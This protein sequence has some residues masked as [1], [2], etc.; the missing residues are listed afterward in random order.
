MNVIARCR[1]GQRRAIFS[2][3]TLRLAFIFV[4]LPVLPA[5]YASASNCTNWGTISFFA[6]VSLND[7][8]RCLDLGYDP[9]FLDGNAETPLFHMLRLRAPAAYIRVLLEYEANPNFRSESGLRVMHLAAFLTRDPKTIHDLVRAGGRPNEPMEG[10]FFPIHFSAQSNPDARIT[11]ALLENG[12]DP[13]VVNEA[14]W[15]PLASAILFNRN[16]GVA[17]G[18]LGEHLGHYLPRQGT[19]ASSGWQPG[20][21]RARCW[22][23]GP[24]EM[25]GLECFYM[26][27]REDP[28]RDTS[29]LIAFP[30][31]RFF[32]PD[33]KS[34]GS[35]VLKL[36]GGGPGNP[37]GFE[38][39]YFGLHW[40]YTNLAAPAGRDLY[41]MDPRGVG[42]AHPRLYCS[43]FLE[44]HDAVFES[45]E[46][47]QKEQLSL[48]EGYKACK[49]F[50]DRM[51]HDLSQYNS[52][53]VAGDAEALRQAL[54][55]DRWVLFGQSFAARYALTVAREFPRSVEAMVL[56]GAAFPGRGLLEHPVAVEQIPFEKLFAH[57]EATPDCDRETLE[58][59][60][61]RLVN[62]LESEPIT[63]NDPG[64]GIHDGYGRGYRLDRFVLTGARLV[65]LVQRGLVK[66][67]K[68]VK[69]GVL[70]GELERGVTR[71]LRSWLPGYL[72][73]WLGSTYSDPV[74]YAHYCSEIHPL[75][76]FAADA[77]KRGKAPEY[78]RLFNR[79]VTREDEEA[80]CALWGVS[81]ADPVEARS[82]ETDIPTLFL[83]GRLDPVTPLEV[84]QKELKNFGRREVLVFDDLSHADWHGHECAMVAGARFLERKSLD[85]MQG[86][87]A[88]GR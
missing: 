38:S 6:K 37:V 21:H 42:M 57:C 24:A 16:P 79:G 22:F 2:G 5:G 11:K 59:R 4:V 12:A 68:F 72:E 26:V 17:W 71:E 58:T 80:G 77:H 88:D 18:L 43:D 60:F 63:V 7:M 31:V 78:L 56:A 66:A 54:N 45:P 1:H 73:Y 64:H 28:D 41:V 8:R 70:V 32:D 20:L 83:Q 10:G 29:G 39:S 27:R 61:G 82:V 23:G 55:V 46:T 51:Q 62:R 19:E 85:S 15:S 40:Y 87:C 49:Q 48:R 86:Q 69:F 14:G 50:L 3:W 53:A 44:E 52:L 25:T 76:D 35:P 34:D 84:M 47:T 9:N 67:E 36:G 13:F 33:R 30:V 81:P 65:D 74:F 75:I